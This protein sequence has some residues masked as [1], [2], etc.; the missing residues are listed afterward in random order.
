MSR[1]ESGLE[2]L[3]L[4]ELERLQAELLLAIVRGH[5]IAA[6]MAVIG[7]SLTSLADLSARSGE[8]HGI[9]V[10][11]ADRVS[12]RWASARAL[13]LRAVKEDPWRALPV[14]SMPV[15]LAVRRKWQPAVKAWASEMVL[16]RVERDMFARGAM[17]SCHRCKIFQSARYGWLGA[18]VNHVA[19]HYA[20]DPD[21][22][23]LLERDV[24]LQQ[25]AKG[26]AA[27]FNACGVPKPVDFVECAMISL[28]AR[29]ITFAVEPLLEGNF[30]KYSSNSGFVTDEVLRNTPHAFSHWTFETSGGEELVVDVQGV[31]D[32]LTDPQIHTRDGQ[33]FAGGNM[34]LRGMALFFANHRCNAICRQLRCRPFA[35]LPET[36]ADATIP[37]SSGDDS[38]PAS[39]SPGRRRD[40][41]GGEAMRQ[42]PRSAGGGGVNL[43]SPSTALIV[44]PA[45]ARSTDTRISVPEHAAIHFSLALLHAR[46]VRGGD[47]TIGPGSRA[48]PSLGLFHLGESA[49]LGHMPAL[50]ACAC[51]HSGV[52]PRKGVLAALGDSLQTPL[53]VNR[54]AAL[55]FMLQ[56]A[57][58][59]VSS[60][61]CAVAFAYRHGLGAPASAALAVKWYR[62]A[63]GVRGECDEMQEEYEAEGARLE[64]GDAS[65]H[66]VL[67]SLAEL[68]E[69]GGSD[70]LPDVPTARNFEYLA[71]SRLRREHDE[72]EA[73]DEEE[74]HAADSGDGDLCSS[75]SDAVHSPCIAGNRDGELV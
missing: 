38:I 73:E 68:Y 3:S 58:G 2:K 31:G 54:Q 64:G 75:S 70:L 45:A 33:G 66:S 55:R 51:L 23:A 26:H 49:A 25:A 4:T 41:W 43:P 42:H 71:R 62:R 18:G 35:R 30:T 5:G 74:D 24:K 29:A 20:G 16:I 17:R 13:A 48:S 56:A 27:R 60:A 52:K 19:K 34:G 6:A 22:T 21:S 72:M 63:I 11:A 47:E 59:Q 53:A 28:D 50:L 36:A 15:E 46:A 8:G 39:P 61:M 57:E 44:T 65:E 12:R 14:T 40:E 1:H 10:T 67:C 37:L 32:L 9:V 7:K 69:T